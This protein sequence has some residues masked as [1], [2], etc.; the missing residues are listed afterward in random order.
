[1]VAHAF[2]PAGGQYAKGVLPSHRRLNER[3]L[4]GAELCVAPVAAQQLVQG[5]FHG[6][7]R[8]LGVCPVN[9]GS[10]RGA[11]A[12]CAARAY[13]PATRPQHSSTKRWW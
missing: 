10:V 12:G 2:A 11:A 5:A 1:L 4:P 6:V 8:G 7:G 3:Q 13:L 9:I